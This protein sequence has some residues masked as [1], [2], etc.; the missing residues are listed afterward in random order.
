MESPEQALQ[1]AVV[2][3][4]ESD[5]ALAGLIGPHG[6]FD[7]LVDKAA[8]PYLVLGPMTTFDWSTATEAGTEHVFTLEAWSGAAGK[9]EVQEIAAAV[10]A[11]LHDGPLPL[12]SGTLVNLR[13]ERV[14]TERLAGHRLHRATMRLRAVVEAD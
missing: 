10:R 6:V 11:V 8:L 3:A 7:R 1:A 4:L 12:A 2:A 9:R 13:L 14:L 5:P